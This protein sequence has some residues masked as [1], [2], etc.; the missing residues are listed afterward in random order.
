MAEETDQEHGAAVSAGGGGDPAFIALAAIGMSREKADA[1][2]D[3]QI[4]LLCA[5]T[6]RLSDSGLSLVLSGRR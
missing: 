4:E 2:G 1:L 3:E 5:G 6:V